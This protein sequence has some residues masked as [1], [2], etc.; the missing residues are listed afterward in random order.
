[1][2]DDDDDDGEVD[3]GLGAG[4]GRGLPQLRAQLT[5]LQPWRFIFRQ[6]TEGK[7]NLGE[8]VHFQL[9]PARRQL[10]LEGTP[11]V[12]AIKCN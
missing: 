8:G 2:G 1:M 9:G 3:Y 10:H 11:V 4:A 12:A 6:R 7:I 5:P